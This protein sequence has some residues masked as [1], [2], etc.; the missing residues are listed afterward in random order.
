MLP[1]LPL[2]NQQNLSSSVSDIQSNLALQESAFCRTLII[3]RLFL[4]TCEN[5][6]GYLS[7]LHFSSKQV[8]SDAY[9]KYE[10]R[11]FFC[12]LSVLSV[13]RF[14]WWCFIPVLPVFCFT[15]CLLCPHFAFLLSHFR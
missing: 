9:L 8:N 10:S 14:R 1:F 3:Y 4:Q 6:S 11:I 15:A 12:V 5:M 2:V 7:V 13:R